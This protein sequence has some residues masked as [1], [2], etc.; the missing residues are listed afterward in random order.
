MAVNK[1][2]KNVIMT[3]THTLSCLSNEPMALKEYP[4]AGM[5]RGELKC[6]DSLFWSSDDT[7]VSLISGRSSGS[8]MERNNTII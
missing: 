6:C 8:A 2:Q 3:T 7:W 4:P 5:T 1:Q